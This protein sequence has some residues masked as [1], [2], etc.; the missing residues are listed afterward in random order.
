[1]RRNFSEPKNRYKN[2]AKLDRIKIANQKSVQSLKNKGKFKCKTS[3]KSPN[4]PID[5][6]KIRLSGVFKVD[7]NP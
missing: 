6:A 2:R 1:M 4:K 7:R 5:T 3:P